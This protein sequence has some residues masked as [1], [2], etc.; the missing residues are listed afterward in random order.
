[1]MPPSIIPAA[2]AATRG[3][4]CAAWA[5]F[6]VALGPYQLAVEFRDKS[7]MHD[8]R[9]LACL[10]LEDG[11]IELRQDLQGMKLAEVFLDC[12]IRLSH[13]SKGCQQGCVEE[14]Y[15]HS[16]ATGMVEFAQR[17]PMAWLWFNLLLTEHGGRNA[18]YDRVVHG[19]VSRPPR[20]PKRILVGG[21]PVTIR[22][23][24]KAETGNAFGW[25]HF[26]N[27]EA[28]LYSGL[29]GSNLAVVALHEITHAVH[30]MYD[31]K[32]RDKHQNFKHAQLKGWLGIMKDNPSAWRWLVWVITFPAKASLAPAAPEAA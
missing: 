28:Q 11:R 2:V 24:T 1:M 30:H 12:I 18:R 20:M 9:K 31:I 32:Q 16:F 8:K 4:A 3:A 23:I 17:N 7:Q 15:T 14:A 27:R 29:T 10:N 26:S 19:A 25:Y 21:H 5:P 6:H 13:F 22:S